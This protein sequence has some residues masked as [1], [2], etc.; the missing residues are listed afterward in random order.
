MAQSLF[1]WG[2]VEGD[3]DTFGDMFKKDLLKVTSMKAQRK[4]RKMRSEPYPDAILRHG[5]SRKELRENTNPILEEAMM[6]SVV[7]GTEML[8]G[9]VDIIDTVDGM[10]LEGL[11]RKVEVDGSIVRLRHKMGRMETRVSVIE[12]WKGDVT[13]HMRDI[14]EAQGRIQGWLLEVEACLT[15]LQAVV[16]GQSR[17]IEMLGDVVRRQLEL[18]GIHQELILELDRENQRRFEG[19]ERMLDPWGRTFGNPILI[20]LDLDEVTLVEE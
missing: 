5:L 19:I 17:E 14:G 6:Y 7:V 3:E 12:E 18:L 8:C 9:M 11:E 16:V 15:Q 4:L 20:D 10:V 1:N 13:E 2:Q